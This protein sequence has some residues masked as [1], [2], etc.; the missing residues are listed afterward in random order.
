MTNNRNQPFD[1]ADLSQ[2]FNQLDG[3]ADLRNEELAVTLLR[4]NFLEENNRKDTRLVY[5]YMKWSFSVSFL[6]F[7]NS[8][9]WFLGGILLRRQ[10]Y[11]IAQ[12][13]QLY[14]Y[15]IFFSYGSFLSGHG[16]GHYTIKEEMGA[17]HEIKSTRK[18]VWLENQDFPSLCIKDKGR[19]GEHETRANWFHDVFRN[20]DL[21]HTHPSVSLFENDR[22]FHTG[23]RNFFTY[24]LQEMATE[25]SH[26]QEDYEGFPTNEILLKL[27][28]RDDTLIDYFL[29][30]SGSLSI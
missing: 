17:S 18:E 16:K 9:Q 6:E 1:F 14:Y 3:Y 26:P 22:T 11:M 30:N 24:S 19:R 20:W 4:W 8:W 29:K 10:T 25:L 21:K 27:W 13:M 2:L 5:S 28:H 12:M 15:S 23:D 7:M